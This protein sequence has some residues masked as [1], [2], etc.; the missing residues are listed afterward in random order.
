MFVFALS[1]ISIHVFVCVCVCFSPRLFASSVRA[2]RR[3]E[4]AAKLQ[5]KTALTRR[6]AR[7][8]NDAE[9]QAQEA[10]ALEHEVRTLAGTTTHAHHVEDF[11]EA[12]FI[13]GA[14]HLHPT[15]AFL[16]ILRNNSVAW[17]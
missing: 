17:V 1:T 10:R 5:L 7:L 14:L 2:A 3:Q 8:T 4:A 16:E 9:R 15:T 11:S 12:P 13:S 6:A